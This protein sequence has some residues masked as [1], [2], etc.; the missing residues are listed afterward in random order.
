MPIPIRNLLVENL[1]IKRSDVFIQKIPLGLADLMQVYESIE[2]YDLKY[3]PYQPRVVSPFKDVEV[4]E[5]MFAA[6]RQENILLH[7]P[8]DSFSSVIDFL[9][10]S[11]RDPQV[12]AIKQTLYRVGPNSPVVEALLEASERGKQVAVLVELK[13]R[14]DEESNIGWAR[15]LEQAGVHVVYGLVGLKTHSKIGM[16][17]RQEA[18]G[19]RRY[20]HLAT[21]NYNSVTSNIYEDIGIFTCDEAIG[22]DATDLFN[23][24]TGYSTQRD[25]RKLFVAPLNLRQKLSA[26]IQREIEHAKKGEKAHLILKANAIVD[27]EVIQLLYEASKAGVQVDLLVRGISCLRPGMKNISENIRVISVVGRFLEHSR[28]FYFYNGGKDE[29]YLGSADLMTRN[30]N[31]RVEVVFPV[32][33]AEHVCYLRDH[34]LDLYL[35]EN[36]RAWRMES[37]GKYKREHL[38]DAGERI[39]IQEWLMNR[40]RK[41]K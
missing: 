12:L 35:K 1:E 39:N 25:Y 14:F 24:L 6:I 22:A 20:V 8:Y 32:E 7:H 19:I 31:H 9:N 5:D 18:D 17:V 40:S 4:A 11:A 29:I 41:N 28:I 3:P 36:A 21:G 34:V 13:A 23:F 27:P 16:V 26:L 2:R 10:A 33:N 30:L 37:D 38:N 15:K